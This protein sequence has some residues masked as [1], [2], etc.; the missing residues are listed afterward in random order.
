MT[1]VRR[2]AARARDQARR[3]RTVH[4]LARGRRRRRLAAAHRQ[5]R[6]PH[7][8]PGTLV[9]RRAEAVVLSRAEGRAQDRV[10][11]ARLDGTPAPGVAVDVT[12]TQIQWTSVRRAEGN[13]FYTWDT[14][15]RRSSAPGRSRPAPSRCRSTIASR[16]AATSSSR[17][18]RSD[19]AL[20][21]DPHLV[22]RARRRLH[23]VGPLRSQPHRPRS[24]APD[25]SPGDT[26]R[27][28]IQSPWEQATAL[29]TT[30]R[31]GIRSH[32]QFALTSTQ[33]SVTCRSPRRHPQRL[34]LGAAGQRA[35]DA[36]RRCCRGE[37]RTATTRKR[38]QRSREAVV[39]PRLRRA[40]GRRRLKRLDVEVTADQE[41]YRPAKAAK[42]GVDVKDRAGTRRASEVTLWAVD[43][44]V[45]S[46]TDYARRTSSGRCTSRK[47]CRS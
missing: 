28:M 3:R 30:E 29:V 5:S 25:L 15:R 7:R 16:T 24:R 42:V 14:E 22:L 37:W 8:A 40:E 46:L 9:Y 21:G 39:P 34:R 26:A 20:C 17:P 36:R 38:C 32:R 44:G 13:G 11:A 18:R 41:E 35:H 6:Q 43:Y 19:G 31:E 47:H 33:Q 23:R 4:L 45:L 27:I 10:V 1:P 2:P 12:L